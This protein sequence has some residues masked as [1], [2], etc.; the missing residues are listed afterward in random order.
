MQFALNFAQA[1][2]PLKKIPRDRFLSI[3]PT[4][5]GGMIDRLLTSRVE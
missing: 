4:T 5:E 3:Y 2:S 1:A